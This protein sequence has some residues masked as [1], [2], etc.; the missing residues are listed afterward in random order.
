MAQ[1]EEPPGA[2]PAETISSAP[3]FGQE[4][5]VDELTDAQ[6]EQL[7]ETANEASGAARNAWLGFV[8]V[9]A[10]LL[11]TIA[12]TGHRDLLL[13]NPVTL[14][15]VD[16]KLPLSNFYVFA[17]LLFWL[18]H[19]GLFIQ[20]AVT[21]KKL[22]ALTRSLAALRGDRPPGYE[23][24]IRGR[25]HHYSFAQ[26][27]A[28]AYGHDVPLEDEAERTATVHRLLMRLILWTSFVVLPGL[29]FLYF[30]IGF[31]PYHDAAITGWQRILLMADVALLWAFWPIIRYD[32]PRWWDCVRSYPR[33]WIVA[34]IA[35]TVAIV[36]LS[37][38]VA[39][40]PGET[41]DR[42]M[43]GLWPAE[44]R[45]ERQIFWPTA[46]LFEGEVRDDTLRP[47]SWFSRNLV[48]VQED[49]V[50]DDEKLDEREVSLSLR[51]RDLRYSFLTASDLHRADLAHAKL[52]GAIL[53]RTNLQGA[54][55]DGADLRAAF[56][57]DTDLEG[58]TL[59]KAD[60]RG[61]FLW[62]VNARGADLFD[63]ELQDTEW[64]D[65]DLRG[66]D[67]SSA[68]LQ[69][70]NLH[71]T[72]LQGAGLRNARLQGAN[73]YGADLRGADLRIAHLEGAILEGAD[74]R[75]ANLKT[76]HLEG[77]GLW[78]AD[79]RGADLREAGIWLAVFPGPAR[80]FHLADLR[81]AEISAPSEADRKALR[82]FAEGATEIGDPHNRILR[83]LARVL[84]TPPPDWLDKAKWE[85]VIAPQSTPDP[86][87]LGTFLAGLACNDD[88][89]HVARGVVGRMLRLQE[90]GAEMQ[91]IFVR[92]LL[93]ARAEACAGRLHL[94]PATLFRLR[95][96]D[97]AQTGEP[98]PDLGTMDQ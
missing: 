69:G 11:V 35:A 7:L 44:R 71:E 41:T 40:L 2:N 57:D 88:D 15:I 26:Y 53:F 70:A 67:L 22:T 50:D 61:A 21:A 62:G 4:E 51:G 96:F 79:L 20:H 76:A 81:G 43:A 6:I 28:G 95:E 91:R 10:Y 23:S 13:N 42:A 77:A 56:L 80:L 45:D 24:R 84:A 27:L 9:M 1:N 52:Q 55:L 93:G 46:W 94:K 19:L 12:S 72:N 8:L 17:P 74:L 60:L 98:V 31:L 29:T 64:S 73:L 47:D 97:A 90:N 38:C 78:R 37:L 63:A 49:L 85:A 48:V 18:L 39:T 54:S 87:E 66:A 5:K 3:A 58:A 75:G 89:G 92:L 32:R 82:V 33:S 68:R 59:T 16:V 34:K 30:Q 14:P 83:R 25:L 36:F 86:R 65:A